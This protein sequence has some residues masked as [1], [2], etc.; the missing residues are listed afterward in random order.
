MDVFLMIASMLG[1]LA[2]FLYGMNVM[3]DTLSQMAGGGL[4]KA[5]GKITK[6]RFSGF[7]FGTILTAIVQRVE[8]G[9]AYVELGKTDGILTANEMIPGEEYE[10]NERI[11][12][13]VLEVRKENK[14]N[15]I[16]VN[17]EVWSKILSL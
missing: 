1:G 15:G 4:D 10:N 17:D 5:L 2:L 12:V 3:S 6:S 7:F 9:N 11:K 13:Y 8:K 14:A 16:P